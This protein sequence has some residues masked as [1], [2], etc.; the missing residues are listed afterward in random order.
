MFGGLGS[1]VYGFLEPI[2]LNAH[3]YGVKPEKFTTDAGLKSIFRPT[4]ISYTTDTNS[5]FVASMESDK[6][7]FMG[8]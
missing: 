2:T 6:Y 5:P 1:A 7:P 3:N 8:T 4:S